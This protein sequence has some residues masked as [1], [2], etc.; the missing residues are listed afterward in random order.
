MKRVSTTSRLWASVLLAAVTAAPVQAQLRPEVP[1]G[2][3]LR[4][5]P[6]RID[7][8]AGGIIRKN[9]A[10]CM[11]RNARKASAALLA[12]SDPL[13]VDLRAAGIRNVRKDLAM[14]ECLGREVGANESALGWRFSSNE[15]RDLLAEEDYLAR[16]SSAPVLASPP[17]P[18]RAMSVSPP[19]L[20][21]AAQGQA[22]MFD[23]MV[24][25][26]LDGAD[27]LVRTIPGSDAERVAASR[28]APAVHKCIYAD[29]TVV[30]PPGGVRSVVAYAL[31]NRF[32]RAGETR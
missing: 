7:E 8:K 25:T 4:K 19:L 13:M 20:Q 31:W 30:V 3:I 28:L 32:V 29:E 5:D 22:E 15:L 17:P 6:H 27:A 11:Y 2:S 14:E 10:R 23:C 24:R 9:F 16:F 26:N 18:L 12:H 21:V 1:T